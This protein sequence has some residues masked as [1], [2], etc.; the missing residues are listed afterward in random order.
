[1]VPQVGVPET[2][3]RMVPG[4]M[5]PGERVH[6]LQLLKS[7]VQMATDDVGGREGCSLP[8]TEEKPVFRSPTNS[9]RTAAIAG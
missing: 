3:E 1:V 6:I 9:L 8:S 2:T 5:R 7:F 4:F